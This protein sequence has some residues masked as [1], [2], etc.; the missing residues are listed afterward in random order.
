MA[1]VWDYHYGYYPKCGYLHLIHVALAAVGIVFCALQLSRNILRG[2]QSQESRSA[3]VSFIIFSFSSVDYAFNWGVA[4]Y[5]FGWMFVLSSFAYTLY[6]IIFSSF[7]DLA[8]V[9]KQ[10]EEDIKKALQE[11]KTLQG[12]IPIYAR[13]KNIRDDQGYWNQIE[14]YIRERS[15]AEF[16]HSVCPDC[17]KELYGDLLTNDENK[18]E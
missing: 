16:T 18:D 9:R 17:A 6:T 2:H 13:C 1:G 4:V 8:I 11:K 15:E 14:Q 5:P 10:L 7:A 12:F 3:L